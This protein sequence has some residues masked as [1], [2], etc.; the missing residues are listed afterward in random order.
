MHFEINF[1]RVKTALLL[2]NGNDV[3][4]ENLEESNYKILNGT[5]AR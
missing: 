3:V 5:A 2:L 4:I 1:L